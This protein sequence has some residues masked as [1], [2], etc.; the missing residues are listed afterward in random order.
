[1]GLAHSIS[2]GNFLLFTTELH[3]R[4]FKAVTCNFFESSHGKGAPDGVGGMLKRTADRLVAKGRDISDAQELYKALCETSTSVKLFFLKSADVERM[5]EMMPSP[6][7][8]VS[9]TMRIH[10]VITLAPGELMSH[11][12]SCLCSTKKDLNCTCFNS[13]HFSFRLL[14]NSQPMREIH[15]LWTKFSGVIQVLLGSGVE[16]NMMMTFIQASSSARMKWVYKSNVC[17]V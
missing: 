2:R 5:M 7:K 14:Q 8:A 3:K 15:N 1:M 16:W 6:I 13:Q 12:V 11:D 10:Q 4:G 9:S 17:I